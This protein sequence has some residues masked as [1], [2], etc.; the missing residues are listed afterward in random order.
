MDVALAPVVH[1]GR[2]AMVERAGCRDRFVEE[3]G[4]V[5]DRDPVHQDSAAAES[6][7]PSGSRRAITRRNSSSFAAA[8]AS[9]TAAPPMNVWREAGVEPAGSS[10]VSAAWSTTCYIPSSVRATCV[11]AVEK[12]WPTSTPALWISAKSRLSGQ[13]E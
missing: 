8:Q 6:R 13:F 12:P 4:D 9:R 5:G 3:V 1:R 11:R 7:F 10:C 2:A